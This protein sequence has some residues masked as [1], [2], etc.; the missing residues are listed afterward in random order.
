MQTLGIP[1]EDIVFVRFE[2]DVIAKPCLP[3]FIAV[4][5]ETSSVGETPRSVS[6]LSRA[7]PCLSLASTVL[8]V[9]T[10]YLPCPKEPY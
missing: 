10:M 4:D 3:Y 1:E 8:S 5:R 7:L 2:A 9:R 6:D